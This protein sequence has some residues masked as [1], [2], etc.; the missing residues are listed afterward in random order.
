MTLFNPIYYFSHFPPGF[1][2]DYLVS[3]S[4]CHPA[5][6]VLTLAQLQESS[7]LKMLLKMNTK[8]G[9]MSSVNSLRALKGR[10]LEPAGF[11]KYLSQ[12]LFCNFPYYEFLFILIWYRLSMSFFPNTE[13]KYLWDATPFLYLLIFLALLVVLVYTM[14]LFFLCAG[15]KVIF[16]TPEAVPVKL[17]T[18]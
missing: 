14:I 2:P 10:L 15:T 5:Y 7:P 9:K 11:F 12:M 4:L 3:S 17:E 1:M 16:L 8:K 13:Q 6:S 18:D